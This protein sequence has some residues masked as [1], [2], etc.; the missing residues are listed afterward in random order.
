VYWNELELRKYRRL[1]TI[2]APIAGSLPIV[3][4]LFSL[5]ILD[6]YFSLSGFGTFLLAVLLLSAPISLTVGHHFQRTNG[7]IRTL[8]LWVGCLT[9]GVFLG[10]LLWSIQYYMRVDI[11]SEYETIG[12]LIEIAL[13]FGV[14]SI[15]AN[16]F[17]I[18][19]AIV[20]TLLLGR[21]WNLYTN[22]AT[23]S[24]MVRCL[25]CASIIGLYSPVVMGLLA[26]QFRWL[27]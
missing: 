15:L 11:P 21:R 1:T 20:S 18:I 17:I 24:S 16:M 22:V 9:F 19:P 6:G 23:D 27:A 10:V 8:L 3:V 12:T 5:M 25:L 7:K 14:F 2:I 13:P 26:R 4:I